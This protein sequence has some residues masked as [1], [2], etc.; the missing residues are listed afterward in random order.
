MKELWNRFWNLPAEAYGWIAIV[1]VSS[2]AIGIIAVPWLLA[3]IPHDYFMTHQE[4]LSDWKARRPMLRMFV[5][6]IRNLCG[7]VL[8]LLGIVMLVTPGQGLITLL[9][10]VS[11]TTFPGKRSLELSLLGRPGVLRTINWLRAKSDRQPLLIPDR[12]EDDDDRE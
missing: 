6:T 12:D 11:L 1:S 7:V 3:R 10:G 5:L 2:L 8:A 9:L 4:Y